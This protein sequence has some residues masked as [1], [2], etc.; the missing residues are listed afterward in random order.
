MEVIFGKEQG[1]RNHKTK[2]VKNKWLVRQRDCACLCVCTH[3][4]RIIYRKHT[5]QE[6]EQPPPA[7]GEMAFYFLM[8]YRSL[9]LIP[10]VFQTL[11][12]ASI[13]LIPFFV[14]LLKKKKGINL[15]FYFYYS[16]HNKIKRLNVGMRQKPDKILY[17]T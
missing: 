8:C 4:L 13:I 11:R 6:A 14:H 17:N 5:F 1:K 12:Y 3:D 2:K 15:S 7:T 9:S 10:M 16:N